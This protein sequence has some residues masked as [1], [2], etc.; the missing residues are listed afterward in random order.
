VAL[1]VHDDDI[2]GP[3]QAGDGAE[4]GLEA[5]REDDGA[6]LA[7]EGG[8]VALELVMIGQVA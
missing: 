5:G 2:A 4:I 7:D 1:F 3:A 8:D 6:A